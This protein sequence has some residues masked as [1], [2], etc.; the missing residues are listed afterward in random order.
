[1]RPRE[2]CAGSTARC[3]WPAQ[4]KWTAISWLPWWMQTIAS[5][6]AARTVSP[7]SRNGHRV[8]V[9]VVH[10]AVRL[11]APDQLA[12]NVEWRYAGNRFEGFGFGTLES[13]DRHFARRA[14]GLAHRR[15]R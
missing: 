11:H 13:L 7:I 8:G 1:M 12:R 2:K 4:A 10:R 15:S 6:R 3:R 5:M 14:V 9:A